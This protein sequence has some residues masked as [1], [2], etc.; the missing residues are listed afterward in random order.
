MNMRIVVCDDDQ[1]SLEQI[2]DLL[3]AYSREKERRMEIY[4]CSSAEELMEELAGGE[5]LDIDLLLLDIV[6]EG[7]NGIELAETIRSRNKDVPIVFVTSSTE[8]A[9]KAYH[10]RAV[11]YLL[12]P[13][14]EESIYEMLDFVTAHLLT[15]K[16]KLFEVNT[17]KG[18]VNINYS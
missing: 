11:R 15:R 14:T 3:L 4:T 9:L 2:K 10:V 12:K 18:C 17:K 16:D 8:F 1:A 6:M 5:L 13:L 7:K